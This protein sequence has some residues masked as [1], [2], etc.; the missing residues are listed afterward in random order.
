L[1]ENF[2]IDVAGKLGVVIK[3]NMNKEEKF[4]KENTKRIK[5]TSELEDKDF[6]LSK[7]RKEEIKEVIKRLEEEHGE[8]FKK[9]AKE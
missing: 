8:T 6:D 1:L 3:I 2:G 7:E 9:L 5:S 4:V